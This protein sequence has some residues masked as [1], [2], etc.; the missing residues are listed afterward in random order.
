[1]AP[2]HHSREIIMTAK[3][4]VCVRQNHPWA[5]RWSYYEEKDGLV[6]E[7]KFRQEGVRH[8]FDGYVGKM[9]PF[10]ELR[11][12]CIEVGVLG[13]KAGV[14]DYK[15]GQVTQSNLA[16]EFEDLNEQW[17]PVEEERHGESN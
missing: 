16:Q 17:G 3:L 9:Y 11:D 5:K 8:H 6:Q 15:L 10:E 14:L 1:M 2:L 12:A 13:E 7:V 4:Y